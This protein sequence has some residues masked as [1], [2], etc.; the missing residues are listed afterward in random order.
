MTNKSYAVCSYTSSHFSNTSAI[1]RILQVV[2]T[3]MFIYKITICQCLMTDLG[4]TFQS[5]WLHLV[6]II[7]CQFA[8][9]YHYVRSAM[10]FTAELLTT[11][12][13]FSIGTIPPYARQAIEIFFRNL[14]QDI[15]IKSSVGT[16]S[17]TVEI[18]KRTALITIQL[19]VVQKQQAAY[20]W[21]FSNLV[22]SLRFNTITKTGL[23][24]WV[25]ELLYHQLTLFLNNLYKWSFLLALFS[26]I[27]QLVANNAFQSV[28][29]YR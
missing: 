25:N 20:K 21:H 1:T 8:T 3:N 15:H 4:E 19:F 18:L 11:N 27:N 5:I 23:Y 16:S 26:K 13:K 14:K 17:N 22:S 6:R 29:V 2:Y 28:F 24:L 10:C 7:F 9:M 12:M